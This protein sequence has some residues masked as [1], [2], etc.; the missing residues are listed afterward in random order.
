[1][2]LRIGLEGER[3]TTSLYVNNAADEEYNSEVV[4]P[5]FLHPGQPRVWRMDMRYNF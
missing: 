1:M 4:T 5:L 2:N 3:W